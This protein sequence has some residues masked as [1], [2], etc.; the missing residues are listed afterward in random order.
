MHQFL[1]PKFLAQGI[2]IFDSAKFHL[3]SGRDNSCI[4]LSDL[5]LKLKSLIFLVLF[6]TEMSRSTVQKQKEVSNEQ[7]PEARFD[8]SKSRMGFLT[9]KQFRVLS[10]RFSRIYSDGKRRLNSAY[11]DRAFP[12]WKR[13]V[14]NKLQRARQTLKLIELTQTQHSVV[15]PLG[16]RLQQIPLV[17]LQEADRYNIHL[18][19]NMVEIL[20]MIKKEKPYSLSDDGRTS[21]ENIRLFQ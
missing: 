4:A 10:L 12:W 17:V 15:I 7:D 11:P 2:P 20:R 19:K 21:E 16:T 9:E 5:E 6:Q 1:A 14:K 3:G 13:E 18:R 8:F